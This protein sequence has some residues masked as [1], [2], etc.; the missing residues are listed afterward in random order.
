MPTETPDDATYVIQSWSG[1]RLYVCLACGTSTP[2]HP[3]LTEHL[4]LSHGLAPLAQTDEAADAPD[5][6]D[7]ETDDAPPPADAEE[8]L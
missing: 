3:H 6:D 4:R 2:D 7:A 1:M 8:D 5:A